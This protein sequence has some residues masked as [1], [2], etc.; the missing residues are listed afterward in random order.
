MT[1]YLGE[2]WFAGGRMAV[3]LVN[4]LWGADGGVTCRGVVREYAPGRERRRARC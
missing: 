4:V 1:G 2:G 3:N